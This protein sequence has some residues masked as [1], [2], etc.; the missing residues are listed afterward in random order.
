MANLGRIISNIEQLE[1]IIAELELKIANFPNDFATKIQL[2]SFKNQIDDLYQQRYRENLKRE[3][4]IIELRLIGQSAKYG[5]IPLG[6]VGGITKNFSETIFSTSKF[7]KFGRKG[8]KKRDKLVQDT[9]DLRFEGIGRGSTVFYLS[10]KTSPDLFGGSIIQEALE[11]T[12]KL[13]KSENPD[14]LLEN[15]GDV[16]VSSIKPLS[17]FLLEL[18]NDELDIDL[19]W[20]SPDEREYIWEGRAE[21]I[22]TLYNSLNQLNISEPIDIEFEGELITISAKGRF[23]LKTTNDQHFYGQ[24]SNDL[25]D[26]MK[27]FHIGDVCKG[28]ITKTTISNPVTGK[29]KTEFNLKNIQ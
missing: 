9:I 4:E 8:G 28:I 17:R 7:L 24:F 20:Q 23:E 5:N 19:K 15:I 13:F 22:N 12:F 26:K 27:E 14:K 2:M 3:K 18:S 16:G 1:P 29:E 10:G 25:L 6:F 11:N 21:N